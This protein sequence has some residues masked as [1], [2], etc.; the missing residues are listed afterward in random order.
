LHP[1]VV[2]AKVV[3]EAVTKVAVRLL[4]I[5]V[6]LVVVAVV[7]VVQL[8]G[9]PL[10]ITLRLLAVDEVG[11]LGLGETVDFAASKAGEE[12]FGELV[13]DGLAWT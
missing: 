12:L 8:L 7:L 2:V 5:G 10:G 3:A 9:V 6:V 11:A 1:L 4:L 13:G